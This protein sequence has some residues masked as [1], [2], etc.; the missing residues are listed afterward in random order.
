MKKK[1][2]TLFLAFSVIMSLTI[3]VYA[4]GHTDSRAFKLEGYNDYDQMFISNKEI[5]SDTSLSVEVR[6]NKSNREYKI[7]VFDMETRKTIAIDFFKG[8]TTADFPD[9]FE[10]GHDYRIR[11]F[12]KTDVSV[13]GRYTIQ[14]Y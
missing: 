8:S 9:V 3:G 6:I 2:L 4:Q 12:N 13:A 11:I 10:A 1:I 5:D 14:T 7:T